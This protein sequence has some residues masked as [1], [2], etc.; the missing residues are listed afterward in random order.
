MEIYIIIFILIIVII[1]LL[2]KTRNLPEN[3][4][5]FDTDELIN[6]AVDRKYKADIESMKNLVEISQKILDPK[7]DLTLPANQ[8]SVSGNLLVSG[9]ILAEGEVNFTNRDG[10]LMNIIPA[11]F[12][13][14]HYL[15]YTPKGWAPCDG[16]RYKLNNEGDAYVT[17]EEGSITTPDLRSRFIIGSSATAVGDLTARPHLEIGG[18]ENVTLTIDQM[19]SHNHGIGGAIKADMVGRRYHGIVDRERGGQSSDSVGGSQPH[20]NMP[21]YF[22]LPYFMKL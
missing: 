20:S 14:A 22:S 5:K 16:K 2:Y 21:P 11:G 9:N 7:S 17:S 19:P 8:V 12:I 1:Y 6:Q 10:M 13:M 3:L 4:E 15:G 18:E